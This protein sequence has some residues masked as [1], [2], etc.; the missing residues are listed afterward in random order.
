VGVWAFA[1]GTEV[2]L[3][4]IHVYTYFGPQPYQ[5]AGFPAW[6]SAANAAI[7]TSMAVGAARLS[8][9]TSGGRQW[10]LIAAGP[11]LVASCLIGTTFPMV[12]VLH[13]AHPSTAALYA[14]GAAATVLAA[15]VI[16][17]VLGLVP[18]QGLTDSLLPGLPGVP[19]MPG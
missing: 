11:P 2:A 18:R 15:L 1:V 10:L 7:C 17:V 13:A 12:C 9:V 14:G 19:G 4:G 5:I 6:V 8:R 16:V 3:I